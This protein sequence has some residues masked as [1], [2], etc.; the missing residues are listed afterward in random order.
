V[1]AVVEGVVV[2]AEAVVVEVQPEKVVEAEAVRRVAMAVEAV[3]RC[4]T[5]EVEEEVEGSQEK[6]SRPSWKMKDCQ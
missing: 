4:M 6:Q 2:V 3:T 1:E 5:A